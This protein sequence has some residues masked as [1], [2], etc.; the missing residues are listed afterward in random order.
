MRNEVY[1]PT[2]M[3]TRAMRKTARFSMRRVI[4]TALYYGLLQWLPASRRL[5]GLPGW[6]RYHCCRNIFA[7]CGERVNV[8]RRVYFGQG[9]TIRV[10]DGS[11]IGMAA[12]I[13]PCVTIGRDVLM[14][15][16]VIFLTQNHSYKDAK[17]LINRQGYAGLEEI[18]I[19]DDVWIGTRVIILPGVHVGTGAVIGAGAVVTKSVDPYTVVGGNPARVI[20]RRE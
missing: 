13:G 17:E 19:G 9:G 8:E 4:F 16:D 2:R 18:V 5:G 6:L 10:G 15:E 12:K 20:G 14:G 11:G 3:L 7:S 1:A